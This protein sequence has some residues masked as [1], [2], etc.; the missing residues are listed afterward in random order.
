[1]P[2]AAEEEREDERLRE[3]EEE[4]DDDELELERPMDELEVEMLMGVVVFLGEER[5]SAESDEA[6]SAI[7]IY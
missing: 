1:M 3:A 4:R 6:G 7:C 5:A 2:R